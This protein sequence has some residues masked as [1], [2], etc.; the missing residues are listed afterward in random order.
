MRQDMYLITCAAR[1]GSSLLETSLLSHPEI[2][3]HGE[4]YHPAKIGALRGKYSSIVQNE[5]DNL[6]LTQFREKNQAAFLYKYVFDAQGHTAVG[7][8]LKH[9]ELLLPQFAETR[10]AV[11]FDTD[12]KIIHLRRE[13]LFQRFVSWWIANKV[14]GIT[15]IH[16]E[17]ERPELK[18][19]TI[20]YEDCKENF[21]QV[22]A[23]YTLIKTL[24][25][26]HPTIEVS[27]EQLTGPDG[28][29]VFN[30]IQDFLG[31]NRS[32]MSSRDRKSVV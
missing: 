23:R 16:S 1:T 2:M 24:L 6:K 22:S 31:V 13:N 30:S 21:D 17:S 28:S 25:R 4:V 27:Y 12:I 5:N 20:P 19:F 9:E 32:P 7:C 14:T 26:D 8:K 18:K 15:E 3:S 29:E 10:E 11:R